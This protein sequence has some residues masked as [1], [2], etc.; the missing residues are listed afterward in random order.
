MLEVLGL[1]E[2]LVI[3]RMTAATNN[4]FLEAEWNDTLLRIKKN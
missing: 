4:C 2:Q 1:M 3:L